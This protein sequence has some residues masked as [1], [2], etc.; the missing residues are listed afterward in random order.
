[1]A[2]SAVCNKGHCS[3]QDVDWQTSTEFNVSHYHK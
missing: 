1:M 3:S 2:I